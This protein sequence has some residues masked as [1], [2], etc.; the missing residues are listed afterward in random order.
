M[1]TTLTPPTPKRKHNPH[2]VRLTVPVPVQVHA[3]FARMAKAGNMPVGRCMAEWLGDTVDAAEFM[4]SKMEQARA[5]PKIVARELHS[6]AMGLSD[7]TNDL[8]KTLGKTPKG[9]LPVEAQAKRDTA[10]GALSGALDR[11]DLLAKVTLTPPSSNTG[12]KVLKPS[13][14]AGK[15]RSPEFPLPPALVQAYA[16]TNGVPPKV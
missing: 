16:D 7:I 6:Y 5:A 10:G 13:T 15:R 2:F 9:A 4:A 1:N 12:G 11:A 14:K 8:M 3:V